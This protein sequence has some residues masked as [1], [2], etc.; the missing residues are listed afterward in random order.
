MFFTALATDYDG[1]L[2]EAGL[3]H[4][5]HTAEL[6]RLRRSGRRAILVTGRQLDDLE[7]VCPRLDLFD[8]VVAENGA[9]LF[10]PATKETVLL[11]EPPPETFLK[12]LAA[13]NVTPLAIGKVIVATWEP[14]QEA[15]LEAIKECGLEL[16]II[17][18]K[19]AVMVL[20]PGVNKASGLAAALAELSLAPI[21]VAAVGD[22]ENDHALLKACGFAVAVAN[23]VPMLK[24]AADW[25]TPG[26]RGAG[27]QELV[28]RLLDDDLASLQQA[29]DRHR[30]LLGEIDRGKSGDAP[31]LSVVRDGRVLV[32]GTSG[33]GKTTFTTGLLERLSA[34]GMQYCIVDPEGDYENFDKAV[35][36]GDPQR[37]PS[38]SKV[39]ELLEKP[40]QNVAVNLLGIPLADRPGFLAQLTP[41]LLGL[42]KRAGRP[43]WLVID[44]A[45]HML[46]PDADAVVAPF[47]A[48]LSGVVFVTVHPDHMARAVLADVRWVVTLGSAVAD[49]VQSFTRMLGL[50]PLENLPEALPSHRALVWRV[51]GG[52]SP[53]EIEIIPP[54]GEHLRHIRKYAEGELGE[55]RSFYFRGAEERLNLRAHNLET[56]CQLA[57]GVDADTWMHHLNNGDYSSWL[58]H[59][60]KDDELADE[61]AR[62]EA[63][64]D[65]RAS[66]DEICGAIERRYTKA[67]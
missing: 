13:R 53:V 11:G 38:A 43:H 22:A 6:E 7:R 30:I 49:S 26:S 9:V 16:Q 4:P 21:N 32:C 65:A 50:E 35:S 41:A 27:V 31:R 12:A 66:R 33:S 60:V 64:A 57:K 5:A 59:C 54:E 17:F 19:G 18:N 62:I 8:R 61:V 37:P 40:G 56:L 51:G 47:L 48:D 44:E 42:R 10:R 20:P 14:Q 24:D 46:G 23:A 36:I 1:T 55:D 45:H 3:V 34:A 25:V 15:V 29:S 2:A 28:S 63:K 67:A 58:R 52:E 39:A